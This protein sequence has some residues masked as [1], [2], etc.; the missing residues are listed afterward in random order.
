MGLNSEHSCL[1]L[2]NLGTA[3]GHFGVM[4]EKFTTKTNKNKENRSPWSI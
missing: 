1:G 3:A 4:A 2:F